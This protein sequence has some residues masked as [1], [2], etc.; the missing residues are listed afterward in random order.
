[1]ITLN[2]WSGLFHHD[3]TPL[4]IRE[5]MLAKIS[6]EIPFPIPRWVISS[7]IHISRTRPAVSEITIRKTL[8]RVKLVMSGVP[9]CC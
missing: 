7:P 6:N 1:M 4:G 3:D 8:S 2:T 5:T 9:A